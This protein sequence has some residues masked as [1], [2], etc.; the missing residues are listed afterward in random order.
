MPCL[1]PAQLSLTLAEYKSVVSKMRWRGTIFYFT[2]VQELS[3][4]APPGIKTPGWSNRL[5]IVLGDRGIVIMVD[6]Q[7]LEA[8]Y[9]HW[10]MVEMA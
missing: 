7:E 8:D 5:S 1:L 4:S 3:G 9:S 10:A 2:F 6:I